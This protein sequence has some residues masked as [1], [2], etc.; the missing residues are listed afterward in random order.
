MTQA[1]CFSS[2]FK[3]QKE[4]KKIKINRETLFYDK[5]YQLSSYNEEKE[6]KLCI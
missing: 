1:I 4:E 5:G 2:H 3:S 6:I